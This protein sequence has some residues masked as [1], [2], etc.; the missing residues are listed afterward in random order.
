MIKSSILIIYM[1]LYSAVSFSQCI[2]LDTLK[3]FP[4]AEGYGQYSGIDQPTRDLYYVT[5]L[6]DSGTGS[7]RDALSQSNR[8]VLFKV[9]GTIV[10]NS[11]IT[12]DVDNIY[13]AGQTAFYDGGEGITIKSDGV[14]GSGLLFFSGDHIIIRYLRLRRGAG[15]SS[16]EVSGD[17]INFIDSSNWMLDH[18]SF[19]WST[20][21]NIS[22]GGG[23]NGTIQYS[24]S[25]EGLY[26]STHSYTVD[27]TNNTYQNGHSKGGI[28]GWTGKI[29]SNLTF[30]RN[31]FAH[32]DGRNPKLI[33]PGSRFEVVNNLMYNNRYYNIDLS[34]GES[35]QSMETNVVK[36]LLIPGFDTRTNRY[37]VHT[38]ESVLDKI[39]MKGNI[40]NHR[41]NDT[42]SEWLEVGNLD[43]PLGETGRSFAPFDTPFSTKFNS[44]PNASDLQPIIL[45]DVGANLSIDAVDNRIIND[46]IN[47]TPTLQKT[48]QG[49]DPDHW[50]GQ[51]VYYGIINDPSEV[52]GWPTIGPMNSIVQDIN[53]DG[54]DDNWASTHG[55]INWDDVLSTYTFS[56]ITINNTAGYSARQIFLA[57]LG[58][59]FSRMEVEQLCS[60]CDQNIFALNDPTSS[61]NE[62]ETTKDIKVYP[63]PANNFLTVEF[64]SC[65]KISS[66]IQIFNTLGA[67]VKEIKIQNNDEI[68]SVEVDIKSLSSGMY[69]IKIPNAIEEP[70]RFIKN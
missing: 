63:N 32:N 38:S 31:L 22:G 45:N 39:Y 24:I 52:G 9:A 10:L 60:S 33:G 34:N 64:Y 61:N 7:L 54:I 13:I 57:Y 47:R 62:N 59:D 17:N 65:S 37:M 70:T 16:G 56:D 68:N 23:M 19:S 69:F 35:D 6:N 67:I 53:N 41:T 20:D 15:K 66:S 51:S 14:Q 4:T 1:L 43:T 29:P 27:P 26:F 30:Y 36:N 28:F 44:L 48:I 50:T 40:G 3:S 25:S 21:E 8:L 11:Q 5:N 42:M 49:T 12:T 18:C 58:G 55:V 46:V 2:N